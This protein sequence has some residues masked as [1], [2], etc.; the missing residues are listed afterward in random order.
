ML[1]LLPLI[2]FACGKDESVVYE[3]EPKAVPEPEPVVVEETNNDPVD[4]DGIPMKIQRLSK[5]EFT[6]LFVGH[7][8]KPVCGNFTITHDG[9][10]KLYEWIPGGCYRFTP[11]DEHA[12]FIDERGSNGQYSYDE[13]TGTLTLYEA[14]KT[15]FCPNNDEVTVAS[16]TE[17]TLV[18]LVKCVREGIYSLNEF[19]MYLFNNTDSIIHEPKPRTTDRVM[20]FKQLLQPEEEFLGVTL[21]QYSWSPGQVFGV[22]DDGTLGVDADF[23]PRGFQLSMTGDGMMEEFVSRNDIGKKEGRKCPFTYDAATGVINFSPD[24]VPAC[25]SQ[26]DTDHA[27]VL[28]LT[29][30]NPV[31]GRMAWVVETNGKSRF[32]R[33]IYILNGYQLPNA[34]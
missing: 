6:K 22:Y 27:Q 12:I 10:F 16:L 31:I 30:H 19:E 4:V 13:N 23:K 14:A 18:V 21:S 33:M 32:S 17:E 29:L 20:P 3:I 28:S 1:L 25:L 34:Y 24:G 15:I 26:F 8:W 9:A 5:E 7:T 11:K 2:L